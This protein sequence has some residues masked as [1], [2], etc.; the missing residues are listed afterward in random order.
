MTLEERVD[1]AFTFY[2]GQT[3]TAENFV[4][5]DTVLTL[6]QNLKGY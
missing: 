6:L 3:Q 2:S 4:V 5:I 1:A